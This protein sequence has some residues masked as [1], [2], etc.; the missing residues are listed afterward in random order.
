MGDG[1]V[2]FGYLVTYGGI[3]AY[4]VWMAVRIRALRRSDPGRG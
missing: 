1:W 2:A 3:A 4:V